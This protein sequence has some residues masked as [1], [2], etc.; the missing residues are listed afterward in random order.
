[1]ETSDNKPMPQNPTPTDDVQMHI[2]TVTPDTENKATK[3]DQVASKEVDSETNAKDVTDNP[4]EGGKLP[5]DNPLHKK[6]EKENPRDEVET[7]SP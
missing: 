4:K 2:E 1:M 5:T 7:V 6:E 3:T